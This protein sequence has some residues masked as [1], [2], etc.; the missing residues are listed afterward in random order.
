MKKIKLF[1]VEAALLLFVFAVL[2]FPAGEDSWPKRVLITNDNGIEDAKI[3]E[4]ARA[5]SDVAATWVVAPMDNKRLGKLLV[6]PK[7]IGEDIRAFAVEGYPADCVLLG[8]TGIMRDDPPDLV[9][10]G[11][12]GGANLGS[13]WI[14]SGTVGA[15]R[16]AAF[17][18][19]PAVAVSG[20][21]SS[22]PGSLKAVTR[23][24]VKLAQSRL[25][26]E[27]KPPAYITVS[28]PRIAPD[29]IKGVRIAYRA[30]LQEIPQFNR[31]QTEDS[32]S[33]LET[34]ALTG[35]QP[36][37]QPLP[38]DCDVSL[39][40]QGY[41]VIVPMIADEIHREALVL[42]KDKPPSIPEWDYK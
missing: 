29:K 24:V 9:V 22:I 16:I 12:N 42:L 21:D 25:I 11:I 32:K 13:D 6:E 34:W 1:I 27:L 20:L 7:N 10:S 33:N 30:G 31:K 14:F 40:E 18:G 39:V 5:F 2:S 37:S 3:I 4:L 17:A 35:T 15:A 28:L 23:W 41:I 36:V 26:Q 38:P 8:L 19:F